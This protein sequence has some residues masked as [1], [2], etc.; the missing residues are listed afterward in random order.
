MAAGRAI[1]LIDGEHH[2]GMVRE[3]LDGLDPVAVV[4]CGG[5]EKHGGPS[6]ATTAGRC[7]KTRRPRSASWLGPPSAWWTWPTSRPIPHPPAC[8]SRRGAQR[9]LDYEAPGMSLRPPRYEPVPLD[10]PK[11]AVI[12]TGKR[13]GKTAVAGHWATLLDDP[14]IV[15]MG[16]GGPPEPRLAEPGASLEDLLAIADRGEH[17]ASDYLEDALLAGVARSAAAAWEA[18][19]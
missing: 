11:L 19:S 4:F 3:A 7:G 13:T 14:V 10:G 16:R 9:G 18:G 17:A 12:G 15:C 5:A 6:S 8:G 1:A 2:P